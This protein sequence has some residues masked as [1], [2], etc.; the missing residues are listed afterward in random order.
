[1]IAKGSEVPGGCVVYR[2]EEPS[3]A[4]TG[5]SDWLRAA[6]AV[7]WEAQALWGAKREDRLANNHVCNNKYVL[8][9]GFIQ[10]KT[11]PNK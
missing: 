7:F 5:R 8:L 9:N 1:M 4:K 2:V 10:M 3:G 6:L 11:L